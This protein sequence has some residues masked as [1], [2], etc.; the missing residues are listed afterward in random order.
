MPGAPDLSSFDE[1]L[2]IDVLSIIQS[3]ANKEKASMI[4]TW[5][6][7]TD[8]LASVILKANYIFSPIMSR[9]YFLRSKMQFT[10]VELSKWNIR[11]GDSDVY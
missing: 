3:K 5:L 9:S 11:M 2:L 8:Q 4:T 10:H 1:N 7:P 6:S